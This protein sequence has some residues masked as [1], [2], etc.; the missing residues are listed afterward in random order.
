MMLRERNFR[1]ALFVLMA[2]IPV[3]FL[4]FFTGPTLRK[5]G[6]LLVVDEIPSPSDAVVVL[7]TGIEFYPRL[8]EAAEIYRQGLVPKVVI[9]GNRKTDT[10]RELEAKGFTR[11]CPWYADAV[12]ILAMGSVPQEDIIWISAEDA[13][14]TVSE[15]EAVGRE[16]IRHQL[17]KIIITTSKSH[18][19]RARFIWKK[20]YGKQ[21]TISMVAAKS[22]P[23][24]AN[25]WW[26][27]ARQIRWVLAEYGAWFYYWWKEITGI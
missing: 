23:Y 9:N 3:L 27:D 10:L 26:K 20:I 17:A 11:C 14:D 5:L 15:A 19:R 8:I 16:L 18:T 2:L 6:G 25:N 1:R 7:N 21:L 12:R 24:D 22:D 13:Y 4:I